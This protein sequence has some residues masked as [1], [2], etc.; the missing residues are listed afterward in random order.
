M[1]EVGKWA[2]G[3]EHNTGRTVIRFDFTDHAPLEFLIQPDQA[4]EIAAL[5]LKQ[6]A[7]ATSQA[8]N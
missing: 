1:I 3:L 2:V 4:C 5:I 7:P 6:Y 8:M